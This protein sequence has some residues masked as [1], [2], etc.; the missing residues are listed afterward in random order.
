[1]TV[2]G[3]AELGAQESSGR[4]RTAVLSLNAIM[5][6]TAGD[7]VH[8]L[9][10]SRDIE[11][12]KEHGR[13]LSTACF[14]LLV[15]RTGSGSSR[16]GIVVGK[17]FGIAVRRNRAKRLFRELARHV[18]GELIAGHALLVFPKRDALTL[19]FEEMKSMWRAALRR[20]GVLGPREV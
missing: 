7:R 5:A 16:V 3:P 2:S 19:P 14:N 12:V 1:M 8:F 15:C 9:R 20:Q 13:R 6:R 11:Y 10:A 17:R 4:S 18:R